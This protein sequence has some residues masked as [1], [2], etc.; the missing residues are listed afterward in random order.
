M[1][2]L[3]WLI[4]LDFAATPLETVAVAEPEQSATG[5]FWFAF[6]QEMVRRDRERKKRQRLEEEAEKI[7]DKLDRELVIELRKAA[8]ERDR[9]DDLRKLSLLAEKH[10]KT[11]ANNLSE[12]VMLSLERALA[13]GNYSALEAFER[14]I[15][16]AREE[17]EFL[18]SAVKFLL[19]A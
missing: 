3:G 11:I 19:E 17:E 2:A 10:K 8:D 15:K 16:R 7:Q 12:R 18:M 13:K 9:L 14:E 4:N 1:A 6:D 5:G